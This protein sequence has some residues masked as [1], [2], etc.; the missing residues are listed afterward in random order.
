[1]KQQTL[2]TL[3]AGVVSACGGAAEQQPTSSP[4]RTIIYELTS[5]LRLTENAYHLGLDLGYINEPN[6]DCNN[7]TR[8][9]ILPVVEK[10]AFS[11]DRPD[12]KGCGDF[13]EFRDIGPDAFY[14]ETS[15]WEKGTIFIRDGKLKIIQITDG[16]KSEAEFTYQ[17]PGKEI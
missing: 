11:A 12:V 7:K 1:M 10:Y 4:N 15:E 6:A 3:L 17:R 2:C 8:A 13:I 16:N 14:F 9:L 5:T